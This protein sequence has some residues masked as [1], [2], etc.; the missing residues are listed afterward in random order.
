VRERL[1]YLLIIILVAGGLAI[2]GRSYVHSGKFD[3]AV[4]LSPREQFLKVQ[5][6]DGKLLLENS[7]NEEEVI[8]VLRR[9]SLEGLPE[10]KKLIGQYLRDPRVAVQA[11]AVEAS[12]SLNG[13]PYSK[14]IEAALHSENAVL[15]VAAVRALVRG[16]SRDTADRL[17]ALAGSSETSESVRFLAMMGVYRLSSDES[18]KTELMKEILARPPA[19]VAL[20]S[21]IYVDLFNMRPKDLSLVQLAELEVRRPTDAASV[22]RAKI[23]LRD[24]SVLGR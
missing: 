16:P 3:G 24:N 18:E 8:K 1:S 12:G 19:D 5:V 15:R 22:A 23:Y 10:S 20:R 17:R 14:D 13:H 7:K 4:D 21:E 2:I 11:A 9:Y 6:G